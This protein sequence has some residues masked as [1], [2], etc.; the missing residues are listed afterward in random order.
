MDLQGRNLALT[1]RGDDVALLQAELRQL[2]F[3]I[4]DPPGLFGSTTQLA[5]RHFQTAQG[6][7]VSGVVD[8]R[9]ARRINQAI[10]VRPRDTWLVQGRLLRVDGRPQARSRVQALEKQLRRE[11]TLGDAVPDS[12][13]AYRIAYPIPRNG[14]L[15]LIVRAVG[16]DG[17]ELA[18][19][20]VICHARPV[21]TVDLIVGNEPLRGPPLF[22]RV[23]AAIRP[24][25][26]ADRVV[27]ADLSADDVE[28]LACRLDLDARQLARFADAARLARD[29]QL[30]REHEALFGLVMQNMPTVLE[31]LIAQP[32]QSLRLAL[33]RAVA[34]NVVANS[35]AARIAQIVD[36]LQAVIVRLALREPT[37]EHPTFASLFELAGTPREQRETLLNDYLRHPGSVAEFWGAQRPRLGDAAVNE[38]QH[39]VRVAALTL[40][41]Q[42]LLR[43]LMRMRADGEVGR[44]LESLARF[45]RDDWQRLLERGVDGRPIGAPI[46]LGTQDSDRTAL[47]A[48]FLARYIEAAAPTRVLTERLAVDPPPA[49]APGIVFLRRHPRFDFRR[50]RVG[51]FLRANPAALDGD[52]D[53][54]AT[55]ATLSAMQRLWDVAPPFDKHRT[56]RLVA[57]GI[58]SATQ[59]RRLGERAFVARAAGALGGAAEARTVYARAAHKADTALM[60][61]SQTAVMNPIEIGVVPPQLLGAGIP[62]L[63]DLFGTLDTCRCLHCASVVSPA[64]YLV[65]MLHFLMNS[66]AT[67]PGRSALDVLFDGRPD[68]GEVDLD[69]DN[70]HTA[71][72]YVDLVV[73][74]LENA[75]ALSGGFPF[76][77]EGDAADLLASPAHLNPAAYAALSAAVYPWSLPFDLWADM[78]RTYLNHLGVTRHELMQCFRANSDAAK[79][80]DVAIEYLG[81]TPTER[82]ILTAPATDPAHP[83]WG[84]DSV[85]GFNQLAET[86]N[87][88]TLLERSRLSYQQFAALLRVA[89][90]NPLQPLEIEFAGADCNLDTATVPGLSAPTL[91]RLHRFTRLQRRLD[92]SIEELEAV[93]QVLHV[94]AFDDAALVRVA[95]VQRLQRTLN[96]P[97][98]V[99]LAWWSALL[100]T[101]GI[102]SQ[103]S[104]Y[105]EVFLDPSVNP[106]GLEIFRLNATNFELASVETALVSANL[107]P[108]H[109][110]LGV[111]AADLGLLRPELPDDRLS[112]ANLTRLYRTTSLAK[113]LR[114][115]V[116]EFLTLRALTGIEPVGTAAATV[117][118]V[119]FVDAATFIRQGGYSLPVLDYLLRHRFAANAPFVPSDAEI[120]S[121]LGSLRAMLRAVD[122][123]FALAPPG[124]DTSDPDFVADPDGTRSARHLAAVLPADAVNRA[125]ALI[126]QD[127]AN[128]PDDPATFVEVHFAFLDPGDAVERLVDPGTLT[129]TDERFN[130]VLAGLLAHLGARA[131][132]DAAVAAVADALQVDP[133]L[134]AALLRELV[135]SPADEER[136]ILDDLIDSSFVGALDEEAPPAAFDRSTFPLQF[137]SIERLHKLMQFAALVGIG[138]AHLPFAVSDGPARGWVDVAA[139]V[140]AP[141][142]DAPAGFSAFRVMARSIAA[143]SRLPGGLTD[144]FAQLQ[145]LDDPDTDREQY[146]DELALRTGWGRAD[147]DFVAGPQV[148]ALAYPEGFQSG[149]FLADM[150]PGM[151]QLR[152]LGIAAS[153]AHTW[154]AAAVDADIARTVLQAARSRYPDKNAWLAVARPLRDA[155]RERQRAALVDFLVEERGLRSANDL[156]GHFLV[157]V[158]MSPCMLTSRLVLATSSVQLFVQRCL[159][160]LEPD[161]PP[162]SID[163]AQWSWMKNYRF[164]EANRLVFLFPENWI[165]P[166]LRDDK[167][168][169][170]IALEQGLLHDDITGPTVEREY[171]KYLHALDEVANLEIAGIGRGDWGAERDVLHV[172]GR[173]RNAPRRYHYRRWNHIAWTPWEPVEAGI[174]G[175]H[176]APAVWNRRLYA[177]WPLLTDTAMTVE[178][179]PEEGF[180]F[181]KSLEK[182]QV[183][184]LQWS[185]Y[186]DGQWTPKQV[187][188]V[189]VPLI[190]IVDGKKAL[191]AVYDPADLSFWTPSIAQD[192][193]TVA[194]DIRPESFALPDLVVHAAGESGTGEAPV[195]PEWP[196]F[197]HSV[198]QFNQMRA[199][200][201]GTAP[202]QVHTRLGDDEPGTVTVLDR[203]PR[204][205]SVVFEQ[206]E[207][208]FFCRTPFFVQDPQRSFFV[209][210]D[211]RYLLDPGSGSPLVGDA[212][213]GLDPTHAPQEPVDATPLDLPA[214]IVT[215]HAEAARNALALV[216][217]PDSVPSPA[218]PAVLAGHWE[219]RSFWFQSHYHPFVRLLT[220]QL[221]RFAIE[222]ILKP[223]ARMEPDVTGAFEP[224]RRQQLF[225][226]Y[227]ANEYGPQVDVVK[228]MLRIPPELPANIAERMRMAVQPR[229][230]FD[231]SFGGAYSIYNW[232]LFFH[233]PLMVAKR[234][235]ASRRFEEAHR[236]FSFIF[237]PTDPPE[238]PQPGQQDL[239]EWVWNI[240]PFVEYGQGQ[241]IQRL[242]L[243]LSSTGLTAEEKTLRQGLNDQIKA[244]RQTPYNPHLIACMRVQPY[245]MA[246]VMAYL[247]NLIAWADD[248]FRRDT[249]ESVNEASQLYVLAAE[250]LGDRPREIA[251][252]EGSPRRI[253]GEEV[254]S[255]NDLRPHLDAFS[256]ALV[257]LETIVYPGE[258]D[259]GV[260]NSGGLFDIADFQSPS[261]PAPDL[262]PDVGAGAPVPAVVGPTLFFCIPRNEKL[263]GYWDTVSD[264]LFKIRHCMNIEGVVRQL[265]LFQPPID[266]ALLVRAAAAGIAIGDALTSLTGPLPSVRF[267]VLIDR[268]REL[269][270]QVGSLGALTL[271]ALEKRDVEQLSLLRS[272]QEKELLKSMRS[273]K[274]AQVLQ[275]EQ[276]VEALR[277]SK[278]VADA[279]HQHLVDLLAA[280]PADGDNLDDSERDTR[281]SMLK[282]TTAEEEAASARETAANLA[283]FLP[284]FA[285]GWSG[286]GPLGSATIGRGNFIALAEFGAVKASNRAAAATG[287]ANSASLTGNWNRREQQW[288]HERDVAQL[289][290]DHIDALIVAAELRLDLARHESDVHEQ[291]LAH[292]EAMDA[293]MR[294][295]YTGSDLYGWMIGRVSTV[296]FQ[297]Y[298]LALELARRAERAFRFELGVTQSDFI[299]PGHWDSLKKG[300]LAG[301]SLALDL[302]RMASAYLEQHKREYELNKPVSLRQ[303]DPLALLEL[304]ATGSCQLSLPE[305]LFDLDGPGHYLRRLKTVSISIPSVVGPYASVNCTASL[306]SSSVR[307]SPLLAGGYARA[308][309]DASR[310]VD[311]FGA[312][313]AVVTSTGNADSGLFE[314]NLRDERY[315]PFEGSGAIG[316]WR[317]ELPTEFRQFD[318]TTISDVIL[319]LR[320]TARDGGTQLRQAAIGHLS[321]VLGATNQPDPD[322][323]DDSGPVLLLSLRNDFAGEWHRFINGDALSLSFGRNRFPYIA[324]GRPIEVRAIGIVALTGAAPV[325][326]A[327]SA[328]QLGLTAFPTLAVGQMDEVSVTFAADAPVLERNP[329]AHVFLLVR[330]VIH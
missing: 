49:L 115:T 295:K 197:P 292:A 206:D 247:D 159:L 157:D 62:Q 319:H 284:D 145:R 158:E 92:W 152:R 186:R 285:V 235:S 4:A 299:K 190:S 297:V 14:S 5:V 43:Q 113:A 175:D 250:I 269:A 259:A 326:T 256:N 160:N 199:Q 234:L 294:A 208:P 120:G 102:G 121:L 39:V 260:S 68:I 214:Q 137:A 42:P 108:I 26:A 264:R 48:R 221:N 200:G 272:A 3:E 279:R 116:A 114:L 88:G 198:H 131:R 16:A 76:Q 255:F 125:L 257:E 288:M 167:S 303:L 270:Q 172:F 287:Q 103:P 134:A 238:Q 82:A 6:L 290:L 25:L 232:E 305:W 179:P 50:E 32:P 40:N 308:G 107:A 177:L 143:G 133:S 59:I 313:Q 261:A 306:L 218:I 91:D 56:V 110:A 28:W 124:V 75:V 55:R 202:L 211:G 215:F 201:A 195:R 320:Y 66:D 64:A 29:A 21:E 262:T 22:A 151:A 252:H 111:S 166:E 106:P 123:E 265:P 97:L 119:R 189:E 24:L 233:A 204:P 268:A 226:P 77:T 140:L 249:L 79:A 316:T 70:T 31:G 60:L 95:D 74:I 11:A 19:S 93:L 1:S 315:L 136:P 89:F 142:A 194:I 181:D 327:L 278:E 173:T 69:C 267:A 30:P 276:E 36:A 205:F 184:R 240:K 45:S 296:H 164:W 210:P 73:E 258:P 153:T 86:S 187:S 138:E 229:D 150:E 227:F 298:Q 149:E 96:V 141:A 274:S 130:Y 321:A 178:T 57:E 251:A 27:A 180:D 20:A 176:L 168:P 104:L 328:Q 241:T 302:S 94:T 266:P 224:L 81:L 203:V 219:S 71:L 51:D 54:E 146:L 244:W 289:E 174:E 237:D 129:T 243:L 8:A 162:E 193:M 222:G 13:G 188:T 231:F 301:E 304:K 300:L 52:A 230:E 317:F 223:S 83:F 18:E 275:L 191:P 105:A 78:A 322:A 155:L 67:T 7:R 100:D 72:P 85:A 182:Y 286:W 253:D 132:I 128:A 47:Y 61:L 63:E 325:P 329:D 118:T 117:Q 282:A 58:D 277:R 10:E 154:S 311:Y 163:T 44:D 161:V 35:L 80:A 283:R 17:A 239:A 148:L 196:A 245:M 2:D 127:A 23:Q 33:E 165:E 291:Q 314:L 84:F 139:L 99:L 324:Q 212:T 273:V 293:H 87:V 183:A 185:E 271:A 9:T 34:D 109:A 144:F 101:R 254:T 209:V 280:D 281:E 126:R 46:F 207:R 220:E 318:Y 216:G 98:R 246:V 310:F 242:M 323:P 170:F 248:L 330:Y 37:P 236:W 228:N 147:I 12:T 217:G 307:T 53:P 156:Y 171:L 135:R 213:A 15:S 169:I 38:L 65:D 90:V 309:E 263:V 225:R 312:I 192:A 41:H 112:R 122:V